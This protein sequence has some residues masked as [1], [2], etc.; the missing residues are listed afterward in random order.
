MP[1][2]VTQSAGGVARN[3]AHA[4][5]LLLKTDGGSSSGSGKQQQPLPL[6]VSAVGDD[7]AGQ[8]LLQHWESM[9]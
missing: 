1:G 5:A 8:A 9:G 4:L 2:R 6:L 7:L 3:V